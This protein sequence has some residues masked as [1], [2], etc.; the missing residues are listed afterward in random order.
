MQHRISSQYHLYPN[1]SFGPRLYFCKNYTSPLHVDDDIAP[2]FNYQSRRSGPDLHF[3]FF[4]PEIST[5]FETQD[6]AFWYEQF[7]LLII[8][9]R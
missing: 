8:F 2:M 1:G 5:V 6:N 9:Y 4:Q 3:G 7:L